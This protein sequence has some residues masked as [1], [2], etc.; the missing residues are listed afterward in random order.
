MPNDAA[1]NQRSGCD[2]GDGLCHVTWNVTH[3]HSLPLENQRAGPGQ[4]CTPPLELFIHWLQTGQRTAWLTGTCSRY[5]FQFC[6]FQKG[7]HSH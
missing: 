2:V 4:L 1:K 7:R 5:W 6:C 3:S